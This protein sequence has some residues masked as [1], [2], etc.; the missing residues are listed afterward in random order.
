MSENHSCA[1]SAHSPQPVVHFDG[2]T[3]EPS[4]DAR[5]LAGQH[6]R[7]MALMRDGRWRTLKA[8]AAATHDP[9]ASISAR[10]RDL[11][12]DR[13]GGHGVERRYIERGL[14]EY[15]LILATRELFDGL[16]DVAS[17]ASLEVP[18]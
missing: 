11:R 8:I 9:E 16:D 12:K 1:D 5:R 7:V 4:R 3:F 13:F 17:H 18:A 15:R 2:A 10:L 14:F 6:S